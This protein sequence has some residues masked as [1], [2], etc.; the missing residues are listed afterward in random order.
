MSERNFPTEVHEIES[1]SKRNQVSTEEGKIRFMG[2]VVLSCIAS[3]ATTRKGMVLK[4]GNALRFAFQ[5]P[6]STKDLDFTA[7]SDGIP[8]QPD[9]IRKMLDRS[10]PYAFRRYNVK[11][12]C[13]KVRRNPKSPAATRPTYEISI[14]YQL[15]ND[16]YFHDFENRT[17]SSVIPVELTLNDLVCEIHSW[18]DVQGLQVCSLEDILAEKLRSLLQQKIRNRNRWQDVYDICTF[19]RREELDLGK[20]ARFFLLKS[21]IREIDARKSSF[22]DVVRERAALDYEI[23]VATEAPKAIIPFERAWQAVISLVDSLDI[24]E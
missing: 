19:V 12:K 6:R 15:P 5:S 8:D 20:V 13:Q 1:W 4:G 7:E 16:R 10:F 23:H 2:Y 17:V 3:N 21:E 18:A 24:P 14:G 22:D 11:A 9:T